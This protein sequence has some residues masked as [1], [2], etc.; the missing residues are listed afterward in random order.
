MS[1]F[2]RKRNGVA[3]KIWYCEFRDH[4]GV[5]RRL[6]LYR[7]KRASQE[8]ERNLIRLVSFR[9][10][11]RSLDT[12]LLSFVESLT[13][14]IVKKLVDWGMIDAT[15][16]ACVQPLTELSELWMT[17][18]DETGRNVQHIRQCQRYVSYICK[19]CHFVYISDICADKVQSFLFQ[20]KSDGL[21]ARTVNAHL[22][23]IKSFI[24]WLVKQGMLADNPL[25]SLGKYNEAVDKRV[26][27]RAMT[28]DEI[29]KLL[30]HCTEAGK[31][32]GLTGLERELV[33]RL[34]LEVGLRYG[35]L[36]TLTR[37]CL[38]LEEK[39]SLKL[40]ARNTKS[41]R[42]DVLPLLPELCAKLSG[43]LELVARSYDDRL[44]PLWKDRGAEML[45][46]DLL[47]AGIE[48][49]TSR[50]KL[51][52]H[53]LRH[54]CATRMTLA[55]VTSQLTKKI[56]RHSSIK[57]TM[58]Y[59]THLGVNDMRQAMQTLPRV[60]NTAL[61]EQKSSEVGKKSDG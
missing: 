38:N 37:G 18:L 2:K 61:P 6:T 27:R 19:R 58:D 40:E 11:S 39:G 14:A 52:F 42:A 47:A 43:Y 36:E 30:S 33:Y 12:E 24:N 5:V 31:H 51:D 17:H 54:T 59:Y 44:F 46:A 34:A 1:I 15:Q 13:P 22:V 21:S 25:K 10:A 60:G 20:M 55:G 28:E 3:S 56:M 50:G 45:H 57:T 29:N 49:N 48:I 32:H 8:A 7:D 41:K 23:G 35:E 53:S 4:M 9:Q 26:D 16:A